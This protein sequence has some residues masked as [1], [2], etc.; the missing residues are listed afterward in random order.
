MATLNFIGSSVFYLADNRQAI[1]RIPFVCSIEILI[2]MSSI[3][4]NQIQGLF[5]E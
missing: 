2:K 4:K 1:G 5:F 3:E